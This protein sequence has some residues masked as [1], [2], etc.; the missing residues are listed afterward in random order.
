MSKSS[1]KY[2]NIFCHFEVIATAREPV[3]G[4]IDNLYGPTGLLVASNLGI[5]RSTLANP[6]FVADVVP[7]DYVVNLAVAASWHIDKMRWVK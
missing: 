2:T 3:S 7:V 4:W 1:S 6:K 5:T